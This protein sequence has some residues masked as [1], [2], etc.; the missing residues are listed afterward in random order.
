MPETY[1]I[2][3]SKAGSSTH[4]VRPGIELA[5]S[6]FLVGLVSTGPRQEL[7]QVR[8]LMASSSHHQFLWNQLSDVSGG[9]R[10]CGT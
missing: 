3:H 4:L 9:D 6:W 10:G 1:P 8:T 7:P 5:T 2:A